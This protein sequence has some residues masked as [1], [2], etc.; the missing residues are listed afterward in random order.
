MSIYR[1]DSEKVLPPPPL[2]LISFS[3]SILGSENFLKQ[4]Y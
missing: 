2:E 4:Q 3:I 1:L